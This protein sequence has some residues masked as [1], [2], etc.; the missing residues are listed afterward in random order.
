[1]CGR[2]PVLVRELT[3]EERERCRA[4]IDK[5]AR[6]RFERAARLARPA[7]R[8]VSSR[9]IGAAQRRQVFAARGRCCLAALHGGRVTPRAVGVA[10]AAER[11]EGAF[12]VGARISARTGSTREGAV[13]GS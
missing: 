9:D 6:A 2:E 13:R 4:Y 10:M 12:P 7:V 1:M 3:A 11:L 8:R 5:Q